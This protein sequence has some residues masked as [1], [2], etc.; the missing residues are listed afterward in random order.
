MENASNALIIAGSILIAIIILSIGVLLFSSYTKVGES[1]E[2]TQ[3]TEALTKFNSKFTMFEGRTDITAQEIVSLVNYARNYN[4]EKETNIE[5]NV[6]NSKIVN[7]N[8][9]NE[10]KD[11]MVFIKEN[12][13]KTET[14]AEGKQEVK[15]IYF[16]CN[17]IKD[18]YYDTKGRINKIEFKKIT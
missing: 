15:I 10:S 8:L 18:E 11:L 16:E 7:G 12:S 14:N 3:A 13:T 5:I 4:K 6:P 17:Q 2:Q 1:Y 9:V